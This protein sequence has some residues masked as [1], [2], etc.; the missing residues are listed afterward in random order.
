M[1]S[2]N[3]EPIY[4]TRE[5]PG[6]CVKCMAE[7]EL[8]T[9]LM[10]LLGGD[11]DADDEENEKKF[12]ALLDFLRSPESQRLVDESE[13]LLAEGKKVNVKL[14]ISEGRARYELEVT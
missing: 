14:Y 7:H 1:E 5:V 3:L 11:E 9:C 10:A 4:S 2:Y 8:N 13:R 12:Q 6:R